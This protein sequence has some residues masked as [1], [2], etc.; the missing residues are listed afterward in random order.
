MGH[1]C[2]ATRLLEMGVPADLFVECVLGHPARAAADVRARRDD[3]LGVHRLPIL[4]FAVMSRDSRTVEQLL[5]SGAPLNSPNAGLSPL[6]SAVACRELEIIRLLLDAGAQP[7]ATDAF[8]DTAIDWA[9]Y[10]DGASSL[11]VALL[12]RHSRPGS[13]AQEITGHGF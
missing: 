13:A 6:H 7:L 4:H 11:V 2:L 10:L 1:K 12:R 8:G 3:L 5:E 9:T